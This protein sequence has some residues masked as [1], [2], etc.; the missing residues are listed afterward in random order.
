MEKRVLAIILKWTLVYAS[1]TVKVEKLDYSLSPWLLA[2]IF[3]RANF[4]TD[5]NDKYNLAA[6]QVYKIV[7]LRVR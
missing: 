6:I 4:P 2:L 1:L 5:T 3:F 7:D